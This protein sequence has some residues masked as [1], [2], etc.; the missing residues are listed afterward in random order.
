MVSRAVSDSS[1]RAIYEDLRK[2]FASGKLLAGMRLPTEREL[3]ERYATSRSMIRKVMDRLVAERLVER[4]VGRGTFAADPNEARREPP[5][6]SVF[7]LT[8][9]L[10]AR[11]L[12]EPAIAKLVV[13]RATDQQL[14][15]LEDKLAAIAGA[16]DWINFKEA[17]YDLH[18]HIASLSQNSFLTHIFD[19]II[20]CRRE[21]A[22][23]RPGP[24]I[25][26]GKVQKARTASSAR[27]V[28]AL[29]ARDAALTEKLLDEYLSE[30]FLSASEN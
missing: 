27:I 18:R 20:A 4:H 9:L 3:A 26:L 6:A 24:I 10:E 17:R 7:Q 19:E 25:P 14:A 8:E 13:E 29:R 28:A 2:Q 11:H 12:I 5:R 23:K 16:K 22:W 30:L 21:V 1:G 15:S